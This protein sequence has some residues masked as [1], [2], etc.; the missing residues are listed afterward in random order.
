M[1]Q[2]NDDDEAITSSGHSLSLHIITAVKRPCQP[3]WNTNEPWRHPI[4]S[5]SKQLDYQQPYAPYRRQIHN[6]TV[7][8]RQ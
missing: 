6:D 4:D 3:V 5:C 2:A 7:D 1:R 8:R